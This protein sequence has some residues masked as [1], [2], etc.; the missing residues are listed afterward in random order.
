MRSIERRKF[1]QAIA[2]APGIRL[3]AATTG[4]NDQ[5]TFIWRTADGKQLRLVKEVTVHFYKDERQDV[6]LHLE[7]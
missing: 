7:Y 4:G 5:E 2:L 6:G 1:I 3:G